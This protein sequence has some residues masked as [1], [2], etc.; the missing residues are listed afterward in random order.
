M[1]QGPYGRRSRAPSLIG[2]AALRPLETGDRGTYRFVS[3]D[4]GFS[5]D[6]PVAQDGLILDYPG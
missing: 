5:A 3:L 1:L 2:A 4:G 6:L